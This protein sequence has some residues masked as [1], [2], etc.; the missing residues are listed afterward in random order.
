MWNDPI[1]EEV[2]RV[3]E[4]YVARFNFDIAA[5]LDD[6]KKREI[7]AKAQGKKYVSFP[8]RRVQNTQAPTSGA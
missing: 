8:P 7:E 3:R 4:D 1:V 6:I 2:R 5:M